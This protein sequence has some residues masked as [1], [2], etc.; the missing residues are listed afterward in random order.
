M[1]RRVVIFAFIAGWLILLPIQT[2]ATPKKEMRCLEPAI[3]KAIPA[4][5]PPIAA[6][7][8]ESGTVIVEVMINSK[9]SVASIKATEGHKLFKIF[10]ERS[11]KQWEFN[12]EDASC[13]SR[14]ARI[15][16]TF[17]IVS[18]RDATPEALLPVFLPPFGVQVKG[19][20]PI[21]IDTNNA[22]PPHIEKPRRQG[23]N[24]R[25]SR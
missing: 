21:V 4:L 10:A 11:A 5:Y 24:R 17:K 7:A 22:D 12:S 16:F 6:L 14:S 2:N 15:T 3:V 8:G 19:T 20:K 1:K 25:V 23:N 18:R 13:S 9:G